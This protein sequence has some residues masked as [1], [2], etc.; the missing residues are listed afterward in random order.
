MFGS[1]MIEVILG[2]V[3]IYLLISL[4]RTILNEWVARVCNIRANVLEKW[5]QQFFT[6]P[7]MVEQFYN[8]PLIRGN[9]ELNKK[10]SYISSKSFATVVMDI[11]Q[12]YY[13]QSVGGDLKSQIE[14]TGLTS[15]EFTY[16]LLSLIDQ[17][18]NTIEKTK[19]NIENHFDEAMD[20]VSG[21]YKKKIQRITLIISFIACASMGIDTLSI[22]D[23]LYCNSNL[24]Q[25]TVN[26]ATNYI[27]NQ[28]EDVG[29]TL[30]E[31]LK[32]TKTIIDNMK[33]PIGWKDTINQY[34]NQVEQT[35]GMN[36]ESILF[37]IRFWLMKLIGII[38]SSLAVSLGAP[39][40][41]DTL[42]K[43]MNLRMSGK[44]PESAGNK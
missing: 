12:K 2:I 32:N 35:Q 39:F 34:Q 29:N 36:K 21:W 33:F 15:G 44:K 43:V 5:I 27:N 40:W 16:K 24:R 30:S 6:D 22:I 17:A 26:T 4:I 25:M 28:E 1:A 20:R 3:F 14:K 13:P 41:F 42:G 8:N 10:A 7:K 38:I 11:V 19:K 31:N 18:E 37:S 9:Q 23:N